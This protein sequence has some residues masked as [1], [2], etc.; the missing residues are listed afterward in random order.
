MNEDKT[1]SKNIVD[2]A[3]DIRIGPHA[4]I[5]GEI[6]EPMRA[7]Q[8]LEI[9]AT[10]DSWPALFAEELQLEQEATRVLERAARGSGD[11][12][13]VAELLLDIFSRHDDEIGHASVTE[14]HEIVHM[15]AA[16]QHV[17]GIAGARLRA[18]G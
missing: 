16:A 4:K 14:A 17:D 11:P 5:C 2:E 6:G 15:A 18:A 7:E 10:H 9:A 13:E 12:H 8:D 3:D 1:R